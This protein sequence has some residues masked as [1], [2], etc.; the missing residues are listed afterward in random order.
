LSIWSTSWPRAVACCNRRFVSTSGTFFFVTCNIPML[1]NLPK[2]H[3]WWGDTTEIYWKYTENKQE[4]Y[5]EYTEDILKC[6]GTYCAYISV[7]GPIST[8][9]RPSYE[10]LPTME[11]AW[12]IA[13]SVSVTK[14]T[15]TLARPR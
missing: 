13:G 5:W 15:I 2:T 8:M 9:Q 4:M 14:E 6:T 7:S 11:W 10:F 3:I 12:G 1:V